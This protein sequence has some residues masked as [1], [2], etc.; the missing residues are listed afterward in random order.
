MLAFPIECIPDLSVQVQNNIAGFSGLAGFVAEEKTGSG[1]LLVWIILFAVL[2]LNSAWLF[3]LT[4]RGLYY[5]DRIRR[6]DK[7]INNVFVQSAKNSA[8]DRDLR[9]IKED[10]ISLGSDL[11]ALSR[12]ID[13]LSEPAGDPEPDGQA[14]AAEAQTAGM[15]FYLGTPPAEKFC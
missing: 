11:E 15:V 1:P 2:I 6:H 8:A 10:I 4:K 12:R 14:P 9:K 3:F 13:E 5:R 7:E